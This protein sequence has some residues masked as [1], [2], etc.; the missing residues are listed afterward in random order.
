MSNDWSGNFLALDTGAYVNSPASQIM[1]A[2]IASDPSQYYREEGVVNGTETD[3]TQS[4]R[5]QTLFN[6]SFVIPIRRFSRSKPHI[7]VP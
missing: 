1:S 7:T 3:R 5:A 2:M 4:W 6:I